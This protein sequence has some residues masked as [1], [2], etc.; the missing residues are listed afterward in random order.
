MGSQSPAKWNSRHFPPFVFPT[1]ILGTGDQTQVVH[2]VGVRER[3]FLESMKEVFGENQI[4]PK[5]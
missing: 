5:V 3:V 1:F 2:A 4:N